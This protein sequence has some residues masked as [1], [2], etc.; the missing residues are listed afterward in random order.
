MADPLNFFQ[1]IL[2]NSFMASFVFLYG[3]GWLLKHHTP[4][5]NNFIPWVLGI[6]GMI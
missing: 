1:L 5:N 6:T 3:L 2:E 4:L